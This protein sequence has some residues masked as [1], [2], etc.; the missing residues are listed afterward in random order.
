MVTRLDKIKNEYRR[1]NVELAGIAGK[2]KENRLKLY[3]RLERRNNKKI[4]KKLREIGLEG[5]Q[6]GGRPKKSWLGKI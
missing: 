2:I 5:N 6:D 4:V 3:G 1:G